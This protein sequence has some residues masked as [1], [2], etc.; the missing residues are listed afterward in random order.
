[1]S[2]NI[3]PIV[4]GGTLGAWSDAFDYWFPE[5]ATQSYPAGAPLKFSSGTVVV[6]SSVTAP[7]IVGIAANKATGVTG[8]ASAPNANLIIPLQEVLF[9]VSVD[10][11]TTNDTAA[12]G[13]GYP[14]QFTIGTSYQMLL[15]STSGNYYMGSGTGNPVFQ[16]MGYDPDQASV[17][18]GRVH[19][20]I[21]TS[22]T[23]WS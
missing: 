9:T 12:L 19:V 14:S 4:Q 2:S 3:Q 21:L 1:M 17:I 20:R 18:N 11:T 8:T 15:D 10:T 23:V 16:L 7:A 5:G 13:T 22:Q 6:V